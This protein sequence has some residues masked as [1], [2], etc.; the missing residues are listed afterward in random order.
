MSPLE[1]TILLH[2]Y[3]TPSDI[4]D[5]E[6]PAQRSVLVAMRK[7]GIIEQDPMGGLHGHGYK[8]TNKGSYIVSVLCSIPLE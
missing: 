3:S 6:Y 8:L 5:R 4:P 7:A 2:I 1:I